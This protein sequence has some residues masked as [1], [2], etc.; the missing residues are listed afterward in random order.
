[1][2]LTLLAVGKL[3]DPWVAAGCDEYLARLR[4]RFTIDVVE[5]KR[6]AD[7][8]A[9]LPPRQMI[10]VLDERGQQPSSRELASKLDRVRHSGGAGLTLCIGGP[11]G[12]SDALRARADYLLSLSRLTLPHRL[13]R[14]ILLEQ[15]YRATSILAGEPYHRD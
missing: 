15:L 13:A 1:M 4:G 12:H 5:V 14:V 11:D 8:L 7:M 3:R 6:D 2:R 10:W 9:R